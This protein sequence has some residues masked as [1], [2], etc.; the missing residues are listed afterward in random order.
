MEIVE[1]ASPFNLTVNAYPSS[2]SLIAPAGENTRIRVSGRQNGFVFHYLHS[3]SLGTHRRQKITNGS[4]TW[5]GENTFSTAATTALYYTWGCANHID[6]VVADDAFLIGYLEDVGGPSYRP[7][8][9]LQNVTSPVERISDLPFEVLADLNF[10]AD[11]L[12]EVLSDLN[13]TADLLAETLSDL[14]WIADIPV[15]WFGLWFSIVDSWS[16]LQKLSESFLDEW[17]VI[18]TALDDKS[19]QDSWDVKVLFGADFPD[20][21][22]VIPQEIVNLFNNDIQ[23]PKATV[24]KT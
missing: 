11:L 22:R 10:T 7:W 2:G 18:A 14:V 6:Y 23:L 5:P 9:L 24:D 12:V 1:G 4:T 20:S 16:V 17:H 21:W 15:E 19:F 3:G 8:F 13:F